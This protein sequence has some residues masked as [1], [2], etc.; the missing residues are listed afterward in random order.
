MTQEA[1]WSPVGQGHAGILIRR[2]AR[3]AARSPGRPNPA[4]ADRLLDRILGTESSSGPSMSTRGRLHL[5]TRP[6]RAQGQLSRHPGQLRRVHDPGR[7]TDAQH[8]PRQPAGLAVRSRIRSSPG[9]R[10][11]SPR[12]SRPGSSRPPSAP[13][14]VQLEGHQHVVV[15]GGEQPGAVRRP[16]RGDRLRRRAC[17]RRPAPPRPPPGPPGTAARPP[18]GGTT[19]P[20]TSARRRETPASGR[21]RARWSRPGSAPGT[22]AAAGAGRRSASRAARSVCGLG[23]VA[24]VHAQPAGA[25]AAASPA[26]ADS[27]A[28]AEST[29]PRSC[30]PGDRRPACAGRRAARTASSGASR[31]GREIASALSRYTWPD[32]HSA[33][34]RSSGM[35]PGVPQ[36][37]SSSRSLTSCSSVMPK[38]RAASASGTPCRAAATAPSRAAATAGRSPPSAHGSRRS[39]HRCPRPAP[40]AASGSRSPTCAPARRAQPARH[41]AATSTGRAPPRRARSS[42]S[43]SARH[44]HVADLDL[45]PACPRQRHGQARSGR[46]GAAAARR[47]RPGR[48]RE[49]GLAARSLGRDPAQHVARVRGRPGTAYCPG[50][51]TRRTSPSIRDEPEHPGRAAVAVV[52]DQVPA[53]GRLT[54]AHGSTCALGQPRRSACGRRSDTGRAVADGGVQRLEGRLGGA[55]PRL[56]ADQRRRRRSPPRRRAA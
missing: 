49:Q 55:D 52:P 33:S 36:T 53:P 38:C 23:A 11:G 48:T 16:S 19:P 10:R 24:E 9:S 39:G 41:G 56:H 46:A 40:R 30:R 8:Q 20:G 15:G 35:C 12:C 47:A 14:A 22:A 13:P 25:A 17:R 32:S 42:A 54:T 29:G 1:S 6:D 44:R 43:S 37:N 5:G 31:S 26:A 45:R 7:A 28:R 3:P 18:P 4:S 27:L 21:R 50:R 34:I 51:P 2:V